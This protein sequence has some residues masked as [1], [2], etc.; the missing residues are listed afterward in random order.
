MNAQPRLRVHQHSSRRHLAA[1]AA[2]LPIEAQIELQHIHTRLSYNAKP[3]ACR[4]LADKLPEALLGHPPNFGDA[5]DLEERR[6]GRD[7]RVEPACG[8]GDEIDRHRALGILGLQL[9]GGLFDPVDQLF[10]V[11]PG[12]DP[13]ELLAL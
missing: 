9:A 5:R 2:L 10:E 3:A 8:C 7:V 4:A 13:P 6:R 11:G 12:F 1:L